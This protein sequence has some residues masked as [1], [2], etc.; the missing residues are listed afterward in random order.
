MDTEGEFVS[1]SCQQGGKFLEISIRQ[2][3]I[4][5]TIEHMAIR[6]G[7]SWLV[8]MP[9][10]LWANATP[11]TSPPSRHDLDLYHGIIHDSRS[12]TTTQM[13]RVG[14]RP[15]AGTVYNLPPLYFP[16]FTILYE[17]F[18]VVYPDVDK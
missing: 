7:A 12:T 11:G 18:I 13:R 17:L 2:L 15:L 10:S 4:S 14:Q 5:I 16:L 3:R 9:L 6:L 1:E 8:V